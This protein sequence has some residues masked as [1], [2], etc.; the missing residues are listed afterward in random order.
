MRCG[1]QCVATQTDTNNCG[2]CGLRCPGGANATTTCAAGMCG[3]QCNMGF[4]DCGGRCLPDNAPTSCGSMCMPCSAPSG[5]EATCAMGMCGWRCLDGFDLV[6]GMTCEVRVARLVAPM[7]GSRVTTQRPTLRWALPMGTDGA[8]VDI[9]RRRECMPADIVD[10][11]TVMGTSARPTM[12]LAAGTYFWRARARVGAMTAMRAS[13]TWQFIVPAR[14]SAIDSTSGFVGDYN[15]DGFADLVVASPQARSTRGAI[16]VYYG[17]SMGLPAMHSAIIEGIE[18]N[19]AFSSASLSVGGDINGDGF[20]DLVVSS[21]NNTYVL[22]GSSMGLASS[23]SAFFPGSS[24]GYGVGDIDRDG[25]GDVAI[26][27]A[28]ADAMMVR[29]AGTVSVHRGSNAG[30]AMTSSREL[31]GTAVNEEFGGRVAPVGDVNGDGYSDVLI[32]STNARPGG[33]TGAGQAR[34]FLGGA[35][36]LGAS[37]TWTGSGTAEFQNF[38]FALSGGDINGDGYSDIVIGAPANALGRVFLYVGSASGP[39]A[40]ATTTWTGDASAENFGST[41]GCGDTDR[42]GFADVLVGAPDAAPMASGFARLF[43]GAAMP[44]TTAARGY[45]GSM[46]ARLGVSVAVMGDVSGDG[47]DD[48]AVSASESNGV[49]RTH[50]GSAASVGASVHRMYSGDVASSY[51]ASIAR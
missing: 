47:F 46:M 18:I 5:A 12:A 28:T 21:R 7:S 14:D 39:S 15:G 43:R 2:V 4:H 33:L 3:L 48:I 9:C 49:V 35:S 1:D 44:S 27:R 26:A 37:A 10:T 32:A 8:L 17:S 6:G 23:P 45:V 29:G 16:Y 51:G 20:T 41:I 40:T 30:L 38:G 13:A 24:A 25:Y 34:I 42:D 50:L 19:E 11:V 31:N 22:N 36:G